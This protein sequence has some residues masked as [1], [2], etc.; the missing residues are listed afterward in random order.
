MR[1][2]LTFLTVLAS[3][4]AAYLVLAVPALGA[5]GGGR[6]GPTFFPYT[7]GYVPGIKDPTLEHLTE[8][9]KVWQQYQNRLAEEHAR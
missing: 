5:E 4:S 3:I 1:R 7:Y 8:S 2:Y 9:M 6:S